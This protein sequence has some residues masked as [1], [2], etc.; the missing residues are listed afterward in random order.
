MKIACVGVLS[1]IELKNAQWNIQ[2]SHSL[3]GLFTVFRVFKR[4]LSY[5]TVLLLTFSMAQNPSWEANRLSGSQEILRILWNPKVHYRIHKC[6]PTVPILSQ[7]D[8]VHTPPHPTSWRSISI[9]SSH[10]SLGLP[11]GLF[12]SVF[13]TKTLQTPLLSPIRATRPAHLILLDFITQPI[14]G[15]QYRWFSSL[16][17]YLH[18]FVTSSFLGPN[19]LQHPILK[20]TQPTFFPQCVRPSFTPTQY[21][22]KN[23]RPVYPIL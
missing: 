14:F 4:G 3:V 5:I 17:S 9:L 19:I 16:C 20:H 21:K 18:S 8:P 13:P 7:L 6:P 12:P 1:I 2:I 22:R 11:S 10:L 15:E 23:Y